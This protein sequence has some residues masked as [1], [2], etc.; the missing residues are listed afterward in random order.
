MTRTGREAIRH[1]DVHDY[2]LGLWIPARYRHDWMLSPTGAPPPTTNPSRR[3]PTRSRWTPAHAAALQSTSAP[4]DVHVGVD[5]RPLRSRLPR[6]LP[7]QTRRGKAPRPGHHLPGP[8]P[9]ECSLRPHPRQPRLATG[10]AGHRDC[11]LTGSL[12]VLS[13]DDHRTRCSAGSTGDSAISR[14]R[15]TS[16]GCSPGWASTASMSM[17]SWWCRAGT[18]SVWPV[19]RT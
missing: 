10:G 17:S 11:S 15:R 2:E 12:R 9:H 16:S 14:N 8:P 13:D 6:L 19:L 3:I 18:C 5:R 7:A 4:G 1:N